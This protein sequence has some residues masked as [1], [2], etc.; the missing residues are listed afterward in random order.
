G[1]ADL[2][3]PLKL[4]QTAGALAK[5]VRSARGSQGSRTEGSATPFFLF[6]ENERE[7]LVARR[8]EHV[9]AAVEHV[10][11][12]RIRRRADL[13]VPERRAVRRV[14]GDEVVAGI[15][16]EHE[17]AGRGEDPATAAGQSGRA[18]VRTPPGDA[19]GGR[20]NRRQE[21]P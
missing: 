18:G 12:R 16:R 2:P 10:G 14:I 20:L 6:V 11:D 9:L 3:P 4:R 7:E 8:D 13:R 21:I 19:A 15:A 1:G 17:I 5:A